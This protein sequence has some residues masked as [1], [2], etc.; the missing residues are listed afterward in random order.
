MVPCVPNKL[1]VPTAPAP[2][3]V[4]SLCSLR[5]HIGR[6]LGGAQGGGLRTMGYERRVASDER[7]AAKPQGR[8]GH[9]ATSSLDM[10][11]PRLEMKRSAR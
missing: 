2:P 1:M 11:K 5:R 8:K 7:R 6:P 4:H 3:D 10:T 9:G